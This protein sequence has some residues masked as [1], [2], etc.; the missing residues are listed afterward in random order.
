MKLYLAGPMTGL[1]DLNFP[2]FH[3]EAARLRALGHEI[4][5]PAELNPTSND[6][7]ECMR[8]DIRELVMCDGVALLEGWH[9][10]RGATLE[11]DIGVRLGLHVI[12]AAQLVGQA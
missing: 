1:P 10:S 2:R 9:Q 7:L 4:V 12:E 11:H 5:N 8:I 3:E 6:W